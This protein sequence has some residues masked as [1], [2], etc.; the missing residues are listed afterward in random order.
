MISTS[1][2]FVIALTRNAWDSDEA[3]PFLVELLHPHDLSLDQWTAEWRRKQLSVSITF[4]VDAVGYL[5]DAT[6]EFVAFHQNLHSIKNA[7]CD[8]NIA[9]GLL[10]ISPS[11]HSLLCSVDHQLHS[12]IQQC[13]IEV[14]ERNQRNLHVDEFLHQLSSLL[15]QRESVSQWTDLFTTISMERTVR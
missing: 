6:K 5:C 2:R 14:I 10:F 1:L 3:Q 12:R 9:A 8:G 15:R 7:S 4:L 11:E 13:H